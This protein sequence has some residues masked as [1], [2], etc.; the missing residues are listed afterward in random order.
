M[1]PMN[2]LDKRLFLEYCQCLTIDRD[3][4]TAHTNKVLATFADYKEKPDSSTQRTPRQIGETASY[5]RFAPPL[6]EVPSD[7]LAH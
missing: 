5:F 2:Y 3:A 4:L 7:F 6:H 1:T